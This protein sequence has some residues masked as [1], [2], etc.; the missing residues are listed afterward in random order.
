MMH[1]L[2]PNYYLNYILSF[3]EVSVATNSR[4]PLSQFLHWLLGCQES[5]L[6]RN[7]NKR[8]EAALRA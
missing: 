2:H 1:I 6:H 8:V 5:A 4:E 3:I 7:V